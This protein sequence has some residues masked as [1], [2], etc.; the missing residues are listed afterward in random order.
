MPDAR[1]TTSEEFGAV[2]E[3]IRK[4]NAMSDVTLSEFVE[5]TATEFGLPGVAVGV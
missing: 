5:A 2:G 1:N 3:Q 4:G